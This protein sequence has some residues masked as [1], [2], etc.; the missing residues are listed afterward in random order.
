MENRLP[1]T[2]SVEHIN[3]ILRRINR[4]DIRIPAFQR[5]FVWH[6]A[7]IVSLFESI[8]KGFPIG[9]I[10]LWAVDEPLLRDAV[11]DI[12]IF[13]SIKFPRVANYVLDGMQRLSTIYGVFDYRD[14]ESDPRLNILF[15]VRAERFYHADTLNFKDVEFA[16]PVRAIFNGKELIER[17][18]KIYSLENG[19]LYFDR[20]VEL[21]VIFQ[22]Y[23]VPIVTI[24]RDDVVSVVEMFE[25]INNTGTRLDTVDFMRAVTWSNEF[26]LNAVMLEINAELE[27]VNFGISDQTI[28]KI[29]GLELGREPMPETLLTLKGED[30]ATLHGAVDRAK[31]RLFEV[32]EFFREQ[33]LIFSSEYVPYEGQLLVVYRAIM[34]NDLNYNSM[35]KVSQWFWA[36]GFNE[37]L[38]GKPDHY[39]ARAVRSLDE[40]FAGKVRGVEPRL[41]L[42]ARNFIE[43]RFIQGK[44]LS[45]AVAGMFAKQ[46]PRSLMTEALINVESFMIDFSASHF[47]SLISLNELNATLDQRNP[48]AKLIGNI[49]V[50]DHTGTSES[51]DRANVIRRLVSGEVPDDVLHSQLLNRVC[52]SYLQSEDYAG[53]LGERSRIML[54]AAER[55]VN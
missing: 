27:E 18:S 6:E 12:R 49:Y 23:M 41:E 4:G 55:M 36:I 45:A 14:G 13:P 52:V 51:S 32:A 17:Q 7:Q 11:Y 37:S 39:V 15:D 25:R 34:D 40:L 1:P 16:I 31:K 54:K 29:L 2:P 21:Q 19:S 35:Q 44:A 9:S 47:N 28:I 53:F 46:R 3:T 38:R 10:L 22:E 5:S 33:M 8:H 30:S 48:S 26:D 20:L 50:S 42:Q 43:R 24:T